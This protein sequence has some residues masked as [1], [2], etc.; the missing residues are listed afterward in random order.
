MNLAAPVLG[1][2]QT[3]IS[4]SLLAIPVSS[5]GFWS[6]ICNKLI[7]FWIGKELFFPLPYWLEKY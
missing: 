1:L 6:A 5:K 7:V 3:Q 4:N 2:S